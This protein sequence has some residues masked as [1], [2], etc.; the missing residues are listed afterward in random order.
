MDVLI[1]AQALASR[2]LP[3]LRLLIAGAGRDRARLE[4]VAARAGSNAEFLGQV[5]VETMLALYQAADL[6]AMMCR[7]RWM[8]FE[9]EG[10]GIVFLEAASCGVAQLAGRSGGSAEAVEDGVTGY[11]VADPRDPYAVARRILELADDRSRLARMGA[12]ARARAAQEFDY[13]TLAL[14]YGRHFGLM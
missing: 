6:F 4:R 10:F 9:Q 12:A 3:G 14:R 13:Q 2:E 7:N 1:R 5:P 11:V 8:G